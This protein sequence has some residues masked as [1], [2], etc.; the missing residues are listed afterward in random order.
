MN[1][2]DY[3]KI[4]SLHKSGV[5][6]HTCIL[7]IL[8]MELGDRD[9]SYR[10]AAEAIDTFYDEVILPEKLEVRVNSMVEAKLRAEGN[11]NENK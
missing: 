5:N 10:T 9:I 8:Q 7:A 3:A 11:S 4:V 6:T 1:K 2:K